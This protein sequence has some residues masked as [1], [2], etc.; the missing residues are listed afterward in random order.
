MRYINLIALIFVCILISGCAFGLLADRVGSET[1]VLKIKSFYSDIDNGVVFVRYSIDDEGDR[2][3]KYTEGDLK[4]FLDDVYE[5]QSKRYTRYYEEKVKSE[6]TNILDNLIINY[7]PF[8]KDYGKEAKDIEVAN[9]IERYSFRYDY[10]YDRCNAKISIHLSK[11]ENLGT[12][13]DRMGKSFL[14]AMA[15]PI[16]LATSPIQAGI[17]IYMLKDFKHSF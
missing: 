11:Y 10:I 2:L 14:V 13:R 4:S 5:G 7:Y 3:R 8:L 15:G 17:I 12:K 6:K 9:L 16:D 1:H